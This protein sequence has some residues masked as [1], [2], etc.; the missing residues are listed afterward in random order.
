MRSIDLN[1]DCGEGFGPWSMGDDEAILTI[2]SS[3]N[4]ACGFHAGD[5]DVM[6]ATMTTALGNGVALGAHPGF[7][8]KAGFGRRAIPMTPGEVARMVAYQIGA[9]VGMAALCGGRIGHVKPHGALSNRA[10]TDRATADAIAAAVRATDPSLTLLAPACSELLHAAQ[11]ARLPV[12]AEIFADRAYEADGQLVSRRLPHALIDDPEEAA[13]R[14]VAMVRDR[15]I[16]AHDGTRLA[17]AIHSVCVHGDGVRAVAT[18]LATRK[19]LEAAG[20]TIA[21]FAQR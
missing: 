14:A 17:T 10:A 13:G 1:A 6:S 15:A 11:R 5:P 19:A 12:A 2:V 9:A 21:P 8:D 4:I 20:F 7:D 18:A 16:L 3:A